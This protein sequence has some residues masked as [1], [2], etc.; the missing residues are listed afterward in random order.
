M[1]KLF[2]TLAERQV[3]RRPA[4]LKCDTARGRGVCHQDGTSATVDWQYLR[5]ASAWGT[6]VE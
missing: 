4:G 1:H 6:V 2:R 3:T 5:V